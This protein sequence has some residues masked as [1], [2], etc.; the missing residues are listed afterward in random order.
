MEMCKHEQ[1]T[2]VRSDSERRG[3][4]KKHIAN[5]KPIIHEMAD[6]GTFS[7]A[8]IKDR[9]NGITDDTITIYSI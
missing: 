5:I 2:R 8:R 4:L 6:A 1:S 9:Y 3:Q 7:L